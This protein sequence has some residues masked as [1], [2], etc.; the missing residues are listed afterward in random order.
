MALSRNIHEY[1]LG[2]KIWNGNHGHTFVFG[3]D[4]MYILDTRLKLGLCLL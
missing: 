4:L 1:A 2:R 3:F